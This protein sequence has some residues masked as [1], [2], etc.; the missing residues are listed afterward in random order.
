MQPPTPDLDRVRTLLTLRMPSGGPA[1]S[2]PLETVAMGATRQPPRQLPSRAA[3]LAR[4]VMPTAKSTLTRILRTLSDPNSA[5]LRSLPRED[6]DLF[7]SANNG[8]VL[9]FDN[10][11]KLPGWLS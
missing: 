2:R 8:Y 5:P 1:G 3:L 11:S 6:R 9:A 7:V 10:V 4:T